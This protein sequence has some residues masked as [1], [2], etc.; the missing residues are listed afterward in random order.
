MRADGTIGICDR[1]RTFKDGLECLTDIK[2]LG[3]AADQHRY[4]LEFAC[5]LAGRLGCRDA[6]S[7]RSGGGVT[8]RRGGIEPQLQIHV[9]DVPLQLQL[10]D[11]GDGLRLG[12][13]SLL[14]C[15]RRDAGAK[16]GLGGRQLR[17]GPALQI[18]RR[19]NRRLGLR[20]LPQGRPGG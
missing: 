4:R 16:F 8:R 7:L 5:D 3:L 17:L 20:G 12:V 11:F 10:R 13:L 6:R 14:L 19:A 2:P 9:G 1:D 18:F 15:L